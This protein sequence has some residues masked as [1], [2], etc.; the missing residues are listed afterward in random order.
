M[1]TFKS[2]IKY[3]SVKIGDILILKQQTENIL[4]LVKKKY[5]DKTKNL[6]KYTFNINDLEEI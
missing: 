3:R 6:S 1:K 4:V 2:K 5:R